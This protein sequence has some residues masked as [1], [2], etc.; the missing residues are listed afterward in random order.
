MRADAL[1]AL[2]RQVRL[3]FRNVILQ[4]LTD[5]GIS[6]DPLAVLADEG[7]A[8]HSELWRP[9]TDV[10]IP[11][12]VYPLRHELVERMLLLTFIPWV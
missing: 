12:F 6:E 1:Y 5:L 2:P 9:R 10:R 7:P 3:G 4:S 11:G 8:R